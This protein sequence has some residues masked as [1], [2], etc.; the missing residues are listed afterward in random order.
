MC[1][2]A[3]AR[4]RVCVCVCARARAHACVCVGVCVCVCVISAPVVDVYHASM[5]W[6][7]VRRRVRRETSVALNGYY[8]S[9]KE[10][11]TRFIRRAPHTHKS[12]H[13]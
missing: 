9:R 12:N 11:L 3:R 10:E 2:L 1:V 13:K 5:H 4:A 7:L 6:T 8:R